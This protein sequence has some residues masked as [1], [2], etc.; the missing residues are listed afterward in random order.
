V[1]TRE[2]RGGGR[3]KLE[4][5]NVQGGREGGNMALREGRKGGHGL[6]AVL[7]EKGED[8]EKESIAEKTKAGGASQPLGGNHGPSPAKKKKKESGKN[9]DYQHGGNWIKQNEDRL[10]GPKR[11]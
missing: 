3:G 7:Q 5:K 11:K 2:K 9:S 8:R 4:E 6:I 10:R 1:D